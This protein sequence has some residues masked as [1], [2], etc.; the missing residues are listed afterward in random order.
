MRKPAR[1]KKLVVML[2]AAIGAASCGLTDVDTPQAVGFEGAF[3]PEAPESLISGNA[4]ALTQ[5]GNTQVDLTVSGLEPDTE[6]RWVIR[7]GTCEG[8][9]EPL[10][11]P[12][13][14]PVLQSDEE[15]SAALQWTL[16][17]EL[18]ATRDY[19]VEIFD[20]PAGEEGRLACAQ[21]DRTV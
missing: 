8:E 1:A 20:G 16:G 6:F 2:T 18:N 13:A 9:G 15:G 19:A 12:D 10:V 17:R 3:E 14:I 21:L 7:E 4:A 5:F 11:S